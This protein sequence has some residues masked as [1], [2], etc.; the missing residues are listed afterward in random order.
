MR[1]ISPPT[2]IPSISGSVPC[3][4]MRPSVMVPVLSRHSVSTRASVSMQYSSC[5]R[6]LRA[7]RRITPK[8]SAVLISRTSPWGII[9]SMAETV[10]RMAALYPSPDR[11]YCL[12]N[13]AIPMGR[14]TILMNFR[15]LFMLLRSSEWTCLNT[16]ASLEICSM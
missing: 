14:M 13:R 4:H 11:K 12:Q 16:L 5:T 9:P 1:E 3:T 6:V 2:S 8:A 10:S 15:I 7:D